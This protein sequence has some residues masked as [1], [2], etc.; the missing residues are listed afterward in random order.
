MLQLFHIY[1]CVCKTCATD[2]KTKSHQAEYYPRWTKSVRLC[3]VKSCKSKDRI[4][5]CNILGAAE[6]E[7]VLKCNPLP[8]SSDSGVL[9]CHQHY[10][11]VHR[12][13]THNTHNYEHKKCTVCTRSMQTSQHATAPLLSK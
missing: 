8:S 10:N 11:Q 3:A 12:S 4:T 13:L 9:L 6:I 5:K 1:R 2:F 7:Q